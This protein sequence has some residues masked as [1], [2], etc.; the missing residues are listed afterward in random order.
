MLLANVPF[1]ADSNEQTFVINFS[2]LLFYP[3]AHCTRMCLQAFR[4]CHFLY[5]C[6]DLL[7]TAFCQFLKRDLFYKTIYADTTVSSC[8]TISRQSMIGAAGII[9][10]TLRRITANENRSGV[11]NS[12]CHF[13]F[14]LTADNK[15]LR[16]ISVCHVYR[17]IYI[18]YQHYP[19][20][21]E[22]LH[23]NN[24]AAQCFELF[25]SF[26]NY[27]LRQFFTVWLPIPPGCLRHAQPVKADLPQQKQHWQF[28]LP[29]HTL[30][31]G[32]PAYQSP[33]LAAAPVALHWL[34]TD[35]RDQIFYIRQAPFQCHKPSRLLPARRLFCKYL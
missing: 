33:R 4:H 16:R 11:R 20:M 18:F 17:I 30:H 3:D 26:A 13:L 22:R 34:H 27:C 1:R 23:R 24:F 21:L 10:D 15:V 19:A 12:F 29:A 7:Q 35:C 28:R 9:A 5:C 25:A 8:K 2:Y 31:S 32:L 14:I 6:S